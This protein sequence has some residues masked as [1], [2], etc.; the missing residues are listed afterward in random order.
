MQSRS[1]KNAPRAKRSEAKRS[2]PSDRRTTKQTARDVRARRVASQ[3]GEAGVR[4]AA[5]EGRRSTWTN[6]RAGEANPPS[7]RVRVAPP[8]AAASA[9]T[10]RPAA[11]ERSHARTRRR[12]RITHAR[13]T[14][15]RA[16]RCAPRAPSS[17]RIWL[18]EAASDE[19]DCCG[20][21]A[22]SRYCLSLILRPPSSSRSVKSRTTHRKLGK[23]SAS[24][25]RAS[26][27]IDRGRDRPAAGGA[28]GGAAAGANGRRLGSSERQG[29]RAPHA[30]SQTLRSRRAKRVRHLLS[31][32]STDSR[33]DSR[34][35]ADGRFT[36]ATREIA[37]AARPLA[38]GAPRAH[39]PSRP[40][41]A[42]PT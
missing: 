22:F 9:R 5:E 31:F 16:R 13:A 25:L 3:R 34:F 27:E 26:V 33:F 41:R 42:R 17:E 38:P 37:P 23:C 18:R 30:R 4:R 40:R 28:V 11:A 2:E 24:A 14:P 6:E 21:S 20:L 7:R 39:V 32:R 12:P 35:D 19:N 10:F 8:P 15:R 36:A 1:R 29:A